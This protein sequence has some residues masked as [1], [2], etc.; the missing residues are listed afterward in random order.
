V[1]NTIIELL[2]GLTV[3]AAGAVGIGVATSSPHGIGP[4]ADSI[5]AKTA[6]ARQHQADVRAEQSLEVAADDEL[7]AAPAAAGDGL[8][9][10]LGAI[11]QAMESAPEAATDGLQQAWDSVSAASSAAEA[12]LA[13]AP[14]GVP[15]GPPADVPGGPP[16]AP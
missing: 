7:Q 12:G 3:A 9:T 15:A 6:W 2:L 5:A 4:D 13:H 16:D 11:E 8:D 10:A 1:L 14:D